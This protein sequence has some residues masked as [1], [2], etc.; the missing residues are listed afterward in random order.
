MTGIGKE[1]SCPEM[2]PCFPSVP[3]LCLRYLLSQE[4]F[5]KITANIYRII[6]SPSLVYPCAYYPLA[7][8]ITVV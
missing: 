8:D 2:L 4:T 5:L 7:Q 3:L 6:Y 1:S